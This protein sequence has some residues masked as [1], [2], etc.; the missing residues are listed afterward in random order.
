MRGELIIGITD[1]LVTLPDLRITDA[2]ADLKDRGPS[3]HLGIH[4]MPPSD[5]KTAVIDGRLHVGVISVV[6]QLPA[7]HYVPLYS[8]RALL[9]CAAQHPLAARRG[10]P[11]NGEVEAADAVLP[12]YPLSEDAQK[13]VGRLDH[14]ATATEREGIAFLVL[15]GRYV[16]LL[17]EHYAARWV[18][19]GRLFPLRA[20][21][22]SYRINYPA[23]T[24]RGRRPNRVL[25]T[26]VQRF[27]GQRSPGDRTSLT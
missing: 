20:D 14:T 15:T 26:F 9:Y 7:L 12:A 18:S 25:Q 27:L 21:E 24:R 6:S 5:I 23:V 3:V 1:N 11:T 13:L 19:M 16:G 22:F 4:M 17:P 8:E 2:L 10:R